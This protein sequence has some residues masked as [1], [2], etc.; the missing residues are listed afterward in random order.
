MIM[1]AIVGA[2]PFLLTQWF[3]ILCALALKSP[4]LNSFDDDRNR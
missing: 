3:A 1:T 2:Y 4:I